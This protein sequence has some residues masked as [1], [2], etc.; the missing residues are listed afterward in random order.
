ML[1]LLHK[2]LKSVWN[3]DFL[4]SLDMSVLEIQLGKWRY[5]GI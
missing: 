4:E 2:Y 1:I 3:N 5:I